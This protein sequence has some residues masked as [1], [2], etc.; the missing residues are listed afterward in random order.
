[1]TEYTFR[2][3]MPLELSAYEALNEQFKSLPDG[4][5]P[6]FVSPEECKV[7]SDLECVIVEQRIRPVLHR[8]TGLTSFNRGC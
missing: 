5:H 3:D 2:F 1:M 4:L 8:Y 7:W 6:S